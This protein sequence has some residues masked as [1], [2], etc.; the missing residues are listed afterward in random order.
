L[1]ETSRRKLQRIAKRLRPQIVRWR[2]NIPNIFGENTYVYVAIAANGGV[3]RETD[4]QAALGQAAARSLGQP[5]RMALGITHRTKIQTGDVSGPKGYAATFDQHFP[6]KREVSALARKIGSCYPLLIQNRMPRENPIPTAQRTYDIDLLAGS[7]VNTLVLAASRTL[8]GKVSFSELAAAV[9]Y[10][11]IA[12]V[13]NSILRLKRA[14]ILSTISNH[15]YFASTPWRPQVERLY[16]AYL[17]QRPGLR[18]DICERVKLKRHHSAVSTAQNLFGYAVKQR[19][20][21]ALALY[22]P[23]PRTELM[24]ATMMTRD[25]TMLKTLARAGIVAIQESLGGKGDK[26]RAHGARK[27]VVVSLNAAFPAYSEL[28]ALLLALSNQSTHPIRNFVDRRDDYDIYALF[29]SPALLKALLFINTVHHR[30]LDVASLNRLRPEHAPFTLHG[31]MHWLLEL[32][33]I[34]VRTQGLVR[35]YS[36]NPDFTAYKPLKRLLDRIATVWPDLSAAAAYND[37]L[38]PRR[39]LTQDRNAKSRKAARK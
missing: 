22:G 11:S 6:L 25:N 16:D 1:K 20:L 21:K 23:V 2:R 26:T 14:G 28:R 32:G 30:Q 10:P 9:P 29:N 35:L 37:D 13:K 36:L 33:V 12:A 4:I 17:R 8:R 34:R 24:S 5:A 15:V 3:L 19:V 39:R 31:R 38:K 18:K 27:R 7:T